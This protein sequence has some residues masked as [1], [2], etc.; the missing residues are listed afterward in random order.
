MPKDL[1]NVEYDSNIKGTRDSTVNLIKNLNNINPVIRNCS[2]QNQMVN[3]EIA[4]H[5]VPINAI[6]DLP[7]QSMQRYTIK[8]AGISTITVQERSRIVFSEES[9]RKGRTRIMPE[10]NNI[11]KEIILQALQV[12]G[13][14][15][16]LNMSLIEILFNFS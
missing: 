4:V 9:S 8:T 15:S 12:I 2:L 16:L 13:K 7:H 11:T 3:K 14:F 1:Y 5:I 10:N 6:R